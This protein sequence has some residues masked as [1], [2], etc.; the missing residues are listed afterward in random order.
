MTFNQ[1]LIALGVNVLT[2]ALPLGIAIFFGV[3][4]GIRSGSKQ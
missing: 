2:Q 3:K 1:F 4:Y